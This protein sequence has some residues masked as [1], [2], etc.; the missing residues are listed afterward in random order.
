MLVAALDTP[1]HGSPV[2]K[3]KLNYFRNLASRTMR[4]SKTCLMSF[5]NDDV[6][7]E[8]LTLSLSWTKL[9]INPRLSSNTSNRDSLFSFSSSGFGDEAASREVVLL[10]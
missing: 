10:R 3:C 6:R 2:P 8:S 7:T 4:F 1:M 9:I 5:D